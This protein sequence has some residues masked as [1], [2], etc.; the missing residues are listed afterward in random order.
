MKKLAA[1]LPMAILAAMP[2]FA[3]SSGTRNIPPGWVDGSVN[4]NL[5]PDRT[6]YR[7]V[8][9]SL[10]LPTSPSEH[11]LARQKAHLLQIG[12]SS[13][14]Q[15]I[16]VQAV[17]AFATSYSAWEQAPAHTDDQAWAIV[18]NTRAQLQTQLSPDG[19]SKFSAYVAL[20]KRRMIAKP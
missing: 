14:D 18:Q 11:D 17:A 7:L 9:I 8:L 5:I 4:P 6:A 2:L 19:N 13:A 16:L 15:T 3:Q 1:F 12:L 20:A 10:M